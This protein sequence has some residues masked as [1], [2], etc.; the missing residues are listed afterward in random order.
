MNIGID[1]RSLT[2]EKRSGVGS[3]LFLAI[4]N[5]LA[6]DKTNHYYLFSAGWQK[7]TFWQKEFQGNNV[8][9]VHKKIPNKILNFKFIFR[10]G[11]DIDQFFPVKLDF[12]WLPNINFIKLDPKTRLILTIHDLSFLHSKNFYSLKMKWWH[13]LINVKYLAEK[14][15][16]IIA[17][18]QNTKRDIM[19]FFTV[20]EDKIKVIYPG[21]HYHPMNQEKAEE[22]IK[23][24]KIPKKFFIYLG[25]LEPRKNIESII[26][27]FDRYHQEYPEVGLILVG[28]KG[29]LYQKLLLS[30]KT[31]PYIKYLGFIDG[32]EKDALYFLTKGLIWPSFY[33]GFGFPPLEATMHRRPVI[34][35]HK[36]SLPEIMKDQ[37][38]Y[39]DPYNVS[40]I[41]QLLKQITTD[42][43]LVQNIAQKAESFYFPTWSEQVKKI[44]NLFKS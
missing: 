36:T 22:I 3:Y 27:A 19:R 42:Q 32:L 31:R 20:V 18:S 23:K 43:D 10:F 37:A 39:V 26:K 16:Q 14:A 40:E 29:W 1:I 44:I 8:F 6:L 25:T 5:I 33:E 38:L 30:I 35:S 24:F 9:F 28:N 15:D 2:P 34:V 13:K 12:F 21:V 7:S 41:Y 4:K 11:P 17:V